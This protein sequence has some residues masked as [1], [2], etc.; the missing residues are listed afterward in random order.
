MKKFFRRKTSHD[1]PLVTFFLIFAI[2]CLALSSCTSRAVKQQAPDTNTVIRH[3]DKAMSDL[4]RH[5]NG[6]FHKQQ[7]ADYPEGDT[8]P[9]PATT[10][11]INSSAY[12]AS[13]FLTAIGSGADRQRAI[14]NARAEIAKIFKSH[15]QAS[16]AVYEDYRSN[17]EDKNTHRHKQQIIATN[18]VSTNVVVSGIRIAQVVRQQDEYLAL[19]VLD[20]A[21]TWDRLQRE[22]E[23]IDR[24]LVELFEKYKQQND[25]LLKLKILK[26]A[27]DQF[28]R[29]QRLASQMGVLKPGIA[30]A[31]SPVTKE[32]IE[33]EFAR[34]LLHD[35]QL[36]VE[37]SGDGADN[38]RSYMLEALTRRGLS[39]AGTKDK[40][41]VVLQ[42]K[43]S[44]NPAPEDA[45]TGKWRYVNWATSFS[46]IDINTGIAFASRSDSGRKG[47]LTF[48]K[49][50][51]QALY[52]INNKLI[53]LVVEDMTR[54]MFSLAEKP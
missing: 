48:P 24:Q 2:S 4:E 10:V 21:K 26:T 42:G 13:A 11:A 37:I 28:N 1:R 12:P 38:V 29:R 54:R 20:R 52:Y 51:R 5:E 53:P 40:A 6:N 36:A 22:I 19:A 32:I 43:I 33:T 44:I 15:I 46:L 49:A 41:Q 30:M 31:P 7:S 17:T 34:L 9:L 3:A 50:R 25:Y 47:H 14:A 35:F 16:T 8:N 23:G 18:K 39:I 45:A 27:A